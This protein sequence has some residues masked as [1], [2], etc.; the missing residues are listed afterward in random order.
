MGN[1]KYILKKLLFPH[2]AIL[3]LLVPVA[4]ALLI[5]AFTNE[6]AHPVVVYGSYVLSAYALVV[7]CLRAPGMIRWTKAVRAENRYFVRYFSDPWLRLKVSLYSSLVLNTAYAVFQLGLGFRH[8]SIWFYSLAVYYVLL[9]AMRFVLL[10]E[11]VKNPQGGNRFM[12]LLLYRF[13]GVLLVGMN[14]ALAVIVT[15]IVWQNRGFEHHEITTIAMAA[16]TFGTLSKAIVNVVRYRRYQSPLMSASKV[17]TLVSAV[18][19]VLTLETAMLTA[20]GEQN[21]PLLRQIMTGA[22]GAAV[23]ILVLALAV[24]MIVHGTQEIKKERGVLVHEYRESQRCV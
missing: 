3:I 5:Y 6:T 14:L 20:F 4:A 21:D 18:V 15:Y 8:G 1:S 2:V 9:A 12:E 10:K 23:C 17:I 16:F 7:V 24:S 11:T 22:T 13:C 19:S